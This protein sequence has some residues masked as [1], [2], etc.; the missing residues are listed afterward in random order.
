MFKVADEVV[1]AKEESKLP[2]TRI[3]A[4]TSLIYFSV[5]NAIFAS[6][7]VCMYVPIFVNTGILSHGT[8]IFYL[9]VPLF[10]LTRI[11]ITI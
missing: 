10:C 11:F 7:H 9:T 8:I 6:A 1:E 5:V 4:F 2:G 3:K